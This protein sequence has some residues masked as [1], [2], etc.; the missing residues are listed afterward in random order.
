[1]S[2]D[3]KF[4]TGP[5]GRKVSIKEIIKKIERIWDHIAGNSISEDSIEETNSF[6]SELEEKVSKLESLCEE[7]RN[8]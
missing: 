1:M 2:D 3:N 8:V 7:K 5:V 6:V 4:V